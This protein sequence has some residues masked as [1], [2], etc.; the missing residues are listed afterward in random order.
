M[1]A[2]V[3]PL[4]MDLGTPT[5]RLALCFDVLRRIKH[6]TLFFHSGPPGAPKILAALC[7]MFSGASKL[8]KL[9]IVLDSYW[10]PG[11]DMKLLAATFWS[12]A[13]LRGDVKLEFKAKIKDVEAELAE[14]YETLQT[15][16]QNYGDLLRTNPYQTLQA[17]GDLISKA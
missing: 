7:T 9:T 10:L 14:G 12:V 6:L 3:V 11:L 15:L 2:G 5:W 4:A 1:K 16:L 13:L 17:P 8:A